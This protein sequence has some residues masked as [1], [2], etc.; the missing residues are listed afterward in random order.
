MHLNIHI[1]L[2][3][4]FFQ[5]QA[6]NGVMP[7]T[8]LVGDLFN[9][10]TAVVMASSQ[11]YPDKPFAFIMLHVVTMT[12]WFRHSTMPFCCG[13]YN[14][15]SW[16]CTPVSVQYSAKSLERN[17]PPRSEQ[18]QVIFYTAM[19]STSALTRLMASGMSGLDGSSRNIFSLD[20]VGMMGPERS[21]WT[22]SRTHVNA[23]RVK[24]TTQAPKSISNTTREISFLK[25]VS[26]SRLKKS[27]CKNVS[28]SNSPP[29]S[30]FKNTLL[31]HVSI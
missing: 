2:G 20:V 22:G 4:D 15:I 11:K 6:L 30:G 25:Y 8:A 5:C 14:S 17:S 29:K 7:S 1:W 26:R 10:H 3:P 31:C 23:A 21:P 19:T 18:R 13:K 16:R 28:S 24:P 9:R 12:V 27:R